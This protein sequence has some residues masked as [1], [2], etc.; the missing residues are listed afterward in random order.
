MST[1]HLK[2]IR[3][4]LWDTV[5]WAWFMLNFS[6]LSLRVSIVQNLQSYAF[7]S[8]YRQ[9]YLQEPAQLNLM[10]TQRKLASSLSN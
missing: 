5:E 7:S 10:H 3:L 9:L 4:R 1:R 2:H 8:L 6:C